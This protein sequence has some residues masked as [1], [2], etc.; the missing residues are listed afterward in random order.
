MEE[1]EESSYA[2]R[3]EILCRRLVAEGLYDAATLMLSSKEK[4]PEGN[5]TELSKPTGFKRFVARL[6]S[7]VAEAAAVE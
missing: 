3:Y 2:R 6:A 4:G 1:F 5:Y 7:H